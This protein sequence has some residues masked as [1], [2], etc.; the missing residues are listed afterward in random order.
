MSTNGAALAEQQHPASVAWALGQ[1]SIAPVS[2][3]PA[4]HRPAL[5]EG[6]VSSLVGTNLRWLRKKHRWSLDELSLHSGVSR[7]MLGQIEQGKSVP[8]I[9]TLWQVA[10]AFKVSV[11]WFLEAHHGSRVVV[12]RPAAETGA[13]LSRGE[14]ELRP[15]HQ[16]HDGQGDE[17]Y[18][19]RLASDA[20]MAW[21]VAAHSRRVHLSVARGTLEVLIEG[22]P[23]ALNPRESLQFEGTDALSIR[24]VGS[25]EAQSFLVIR[26]V[27]T[28]V[29]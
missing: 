23:H 1:Q 8:S 16:A 27:S 26:P 3:S 7:A 14:G 29:R 12:I 22:Q 24:N 5:S 21:S 10:Q 15:L 18:E 4:R 17:F 25:A 13:L 11:S 2:T 19:L 20:T 6:A 9:R 28:Q